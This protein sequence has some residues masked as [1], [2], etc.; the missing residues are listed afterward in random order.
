MTEI[1]H[2]NNE[3]NG[4]FEIY[5]DGVKAGEMTY[6]WAET[7]KFIIDHTEVNEQYGGLGLGKKLVE[8]AVNFAREKG[9]KIVPL[10]SFAKKTIEKTPEFQDVLS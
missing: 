2:H 6:T 10:C 1:K 8:A 4:V 9:I 3:K 7:D 5:E